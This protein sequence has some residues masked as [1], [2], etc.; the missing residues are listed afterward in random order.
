V[1]CDLGLHVLNPADELMP[2]TNRNRLLGLFARLE[3]LQLPFTNCR[4]QMS[5]TYRRRVGRQVWVSEIC[6]LANMVSWRDGLVAIFEG[7]QED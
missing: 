1:I 4:K 3:R 5:S 7:G 2:I 6:R